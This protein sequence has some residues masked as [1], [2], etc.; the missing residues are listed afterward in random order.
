MSDEYLMQEIERQKSLFDELES[1]EKEIGKTIIVDKTN[2]KPTK[3]DTIIP[4]NK[5]G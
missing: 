3:S 5:I 1:I 2:R 4:I